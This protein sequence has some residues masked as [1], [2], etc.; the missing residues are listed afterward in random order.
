[1]RAIG[2]G[3]RFVALARYRSR[4]IQKE[5]AGN[6]GLCEVFHLVSYLFNFSLSV[7]VSGPFR[8]NELLPFKP[9]RGGAI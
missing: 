1:V 4:C 3:E 6:N 2:G 5:T 8:R 9:V 7:C